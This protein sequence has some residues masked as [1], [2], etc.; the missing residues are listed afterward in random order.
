MPS[1][2]L[3]S[4]EQRQHL[5]LSSYAY[6]VVQNDS[7]TFMGEKNIS[8]FIN[9]IIGNC[10]E[11]YFD[12]TDIKK[13]DS[14]LRSFS[15]DISIKIRLR[16]KVYDDYYPRL[17]ES[18]FGSKFKITQG[19]Y[20]KALIEDYSRKTF[21]DRE[22]IFY[23]EVIDTLSN[24]LNMDGSKRGYIPI[25]LTTGEKYYVKPYK[26]SD[27]YEAPYHYLVCLSSDNPNTK[28]I[29]ASFRISRIATIKDHVTSY[30]S[31]KITQSEIKELERK[32]KEN[33]V[34][35][36]IGNTIEVT[37]KLTSIGLN[38]Y[39]SIFHQRPIYH[40]CTKNTDGSSLLI[41]NST[42]RQITNYFFQFGRE[43]EIV[44]PDETRNYMINRYKD[45]VKSYN[46]KTGGK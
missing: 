14:A 27:E 31:G 20:I 40:S 18:W 24:Y 7:M 6:E 25:I 15:K 39:N 32:I 29:P 37:V 5:S 36:I 44:S 34:P 17:G 42:E 13:K 2:Q 19:E 10:S 38:M 11:S 26:I 30:G 33:G 28:M 3:K 8:G 4:P 43:A 46:H 21:Y 9:T 35:Y 41:F 45:A 23:K 1:K 16:T 22:S 12:G